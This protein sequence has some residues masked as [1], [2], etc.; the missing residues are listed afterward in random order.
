M[1]KYMKVLDLVTL[2]IR[3][4]ILFQKRITIVR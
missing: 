3:L 1:P 2:L 4:M